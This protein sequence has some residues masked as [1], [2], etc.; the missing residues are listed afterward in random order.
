MAE[1]MLPLVLLLSLLGAQAC[2]NHSC[3]I[4]E[5][6][7]NNEDCATG[8]HCSSCPAAGIIEPICIRS[9]A[10]LLARTDLPFNKYAWL[11]THN[12]FAISTE[13]Q[14][15]PVPRFAPT[16]QDDTVTSQLQNGVRG[17]M[18]DLYDFKNDIW[19][20]H[21]FG[22]ICYDFTAFQPAVETLREV[23]A[24]LAANPREV[25]TIFIEDYVRTQ[26]DVTNVFKAAGLDKFWFPVS[27]M[28]KSGGNWPTLADMIA[29]NQRLLVFTSSQAKEATE[30]IAYQWRYTSENQYGDD[31]MKNGSCRNRDESPPLAS[32]SVSLFVENYFPTTP[33][34]PRE[35]KDH[36][37][38]LRAMLDVCAKSSGNRYANFL[39][40]NF[41]AQSEGGGTFQA[42][43]TLNSKLMG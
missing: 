32:R 37:Q 42:V 26:N 9:N 16:N 34:E 21:S 3:K 28:P 12:S 8:L 27:K 13:K 35:C 38:S 6:C 19:L 25:I 39:A 43:D 31:G 5:R 41:Y 17:L 36:G 18:L 33:F 30:G 4:G 29:S 2:S 40:V 24:F 22:G 7:L 10:T 11:T 1:E 15:F 14:R 20:C 23:E